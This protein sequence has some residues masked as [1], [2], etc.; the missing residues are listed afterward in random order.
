MIGY[1]LVIIS[2]IWIIIATL[3]DVKTREIPNWLNYSLIAI[4]ISLRTLQSITNKDLTYFLYTLLGLA[5]AAIIGFLMYYAKQ[6]GGGDAKLLVGLGAAFVTYPDE[7]LKFFN[8]NLNL[9]FLAILLINLF[10]AGALYGLI[11][12]L[13]LLIKKRKEFCKELKKTKL[14]NKQTLLVAILLLITSLFLKDLRILLISAA[15]LYIL[16]YYTLASI[17]IIENISMYKTINPEKLTEGDWITESIIINNKTIYNSKSP[18]VKKEQIKEIIK[19]KQKG[20]ISEVKIKEGIPFMPSFLVSFIISI[21]LGN[22][23]QLPF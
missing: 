5:I 23:I 16:L 6:W 2:L 7:L 17:K 11:Y 15:L 13:V 3:S 21:I 8:P 22:L 12:F 19:L 14:K 10:I 9:P 20:L 4:A 1:L 18:G